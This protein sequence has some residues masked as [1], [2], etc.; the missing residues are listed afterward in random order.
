MHDCKPSPTPLSST[1]HLSLIA[2]TPLGSDDSTQY[3][4]ILGGLLYTGQLLNV[5]SDMYKILCILELLFVRS[6]STLL[7]AF[8]DADWAGYLDD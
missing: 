7:S 2:G 1:E 8:S 3:R 6:S 4:S 5:F